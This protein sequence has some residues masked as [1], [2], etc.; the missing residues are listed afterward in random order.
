LPGAYGDRDR[1]DAV[2]AEQ[3]PP[4]PPPPLPVFKVEKT[5]AIVQKRQEQLEKKE[6][7]S[8]EVKESNEEDAEQQESGHSESESDSDSDRDTWDD[9]G[10][11]SEDEDEDEDED[12][13]E[14]K[15]KQK[16]IDRLKTT[17]LY[18]KGMEQSNQHLFEAHGEMVNNLRHTEEDADIVHET[19]NKYSDH[20][21]YLDKQMS[22]LEQK[23][24]NLAKLRTEQFGDHEAE[25]L[26]DLDDLD[27][28]AQAKL[29]EME[30]IRKA[31]EANTAESG[32][33]LEK[34]QHLS[35]VFEE[36]E[37]SSKH[38]NLQDALKVLKKL[39]DDNGGEQASERES[40]AGSNSEEQSDGDDEDDQEAESS[41]TASNGS[42][43][44]LLQ[45]SWIQSEL[46][47]NNSD[48]GGPPDDDSAASG[49]Q[50]DAAGGG[51]GL[52]ARTM[53]GEH[54]W[55][56]LDQDKLIPGAANL[57]T[58]DQK[59]MAE[60]LWKYLPT[61]EMK[62]YNPEYYQALHEE[63]DMKNVKRSMAATDLMDDTGK[64]L[65]QNAAKATEAVV[66]VHAKMEDWH[67]VLKTNIA[68]LDRFSLDVSQLRSHALHELQGLNKDR[69]E[70]FDILN[71]GAAKLNANNELEVGGSGLYAKKK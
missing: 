27:P 2:E 22:G 62:R 46:R 60:K 35:N 48:A 54:G 41:E 8:P 43:S 13:H 26:K 69:L 19:M 39:N 5:N 40:D 64:S 42:Q 28:E 7:H 36:I 17:H 12:E 6:Q 53:P 18:R 32:M 1:V 3:P 15:K 30:A 20:V 70:N 63:L 71:A 50:S 25:R 33:T 51:G 23:I 21:H 31:K 57:M 4:P 34:E 45:R 61:D 38:G 24:D 68:D 10:S 49:E 59:Q 11:E 14:Q 29:A 44:S 58:A 47:P 16:E 37:R 55:D 66:K 67:N 9:S 65:A 52:N 56:H